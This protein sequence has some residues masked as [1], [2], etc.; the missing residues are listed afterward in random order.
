VI[1][2]SEVVVALFPCHAAIVIAEIVVIA[3]F[4]E[5]EVRDFHAVFCAATVVVGFSGSELD[6]GY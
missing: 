2:L 5:A 3:A 6:V 1:A 4:F